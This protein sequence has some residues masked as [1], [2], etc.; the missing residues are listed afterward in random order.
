MAVATQ[1]FM[2]II[3][4]W[5]KLKLGTVGRN[6][7]R[8]RQEQQESRCEELVYWHRKETLAENMPN[9][10]LT[11]FFEPKNQNLKLYSSS[12]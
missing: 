7:E 3:R 10:Q 12:V 4:T 5:H 1:T 2:L 9:S 11:D 6:M 8:L